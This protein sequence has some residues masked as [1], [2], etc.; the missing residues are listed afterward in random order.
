MGECRYSVTHSWVVTLDGG[1]GQLHGPPAA[2]SR[3]CCPRWYPL[4]SRRSKGPGSVLDATDRTIF[5]QLPTVHPVAYPMHTAPRAHNKILRCK[6]RSTASAAALWKPTWIQQDQTTRSTAD[7][8]PRRGV[9][10][11]NISRLPNKQMRNHATSANCTSQNPSAN[12]V[13]RVACHI[14]LAWRKG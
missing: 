7:C 13:G 6:L 10:A 14:T 5:T 1:N 2:L 4:R 8:Q 11:R 12:S 3:K 9:A